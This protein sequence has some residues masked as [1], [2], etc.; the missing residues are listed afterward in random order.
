MND[1][2][3]KAQVL[4]EALPYIR[5]FRGKTFVVK[6]GGAAMKNEELKQSFA[7]DIA[8]LKFVGIDPVVV[9]GGG[10][11]IEKLLSRLEIPTRF[12]RGMRVT[13]QPTMEVVEMVLG[14][15]INKEIVALVNRHGGRAVGISG[16]D[17]EFL[18]ARK[19]AVRIDEPGKATETVDAGMVGE[20]TR[21]DASVIEALE[22]A[23]F[24]PI[25][26]PIAVGD[27]GE[28][29]NVNAD[30]AAG[31]IAEA[32]RAEKLILLTDVAGIQAKD[33][34][35]IRTLV[36]DDVPALV[37][38]GVISGGMI[39][40]VEC[41][42]EALRAGVAKTHVIDGRRRHAVLLEIFT[43]EGIGTEVVWRKPPAKRASRKAGGTA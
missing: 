40:K 28:S 43:E 31:K 15:K 6:Y 29:Y 2:S 11:E 4:L 8:L 27:D 25:V 19:M 20:I 37:A 36:S 34:S 42:I 21:V 7:E 18:R 39:P 22:A 12:V 26:A 13:D 9:H 32:L 16:K 30:L 17:G 10:P 5:R 33:G 1:V 41:C 24:I 14:G 23:D 35:L 38:E 3:Q